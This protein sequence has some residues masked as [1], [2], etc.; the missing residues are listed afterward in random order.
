[1]LPQRRATGRSSSSWPGAGVAGPVPQCA[2]A[3]RALIHAA[4]DARRLGMG[5]GVPQAFLAAAASG[6]LTDTEW[7]TLGEDWLERA[8]TYTACRARASAGR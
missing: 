7:D 3:G 4:M 2:A 8:L 5:V 6:Y 1:M